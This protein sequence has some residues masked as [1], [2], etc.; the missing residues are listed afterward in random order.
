MGRLL[1]LDYGSKTTGVALTDPLQMIASPLETI[2]R[3]KEGK[4]RPTLRR[5]TEL[6]AA[7]EVERIVLG[8]PLNMDDS[9]G[10]RAQKTEEFKALLERRL[11]AEGL[12]IPVTLWDERLST[13][14]ADAVLEE[15]EVAASERKQYIDKIA[16]A[17]ILE[18]YMKN[19]R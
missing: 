16:A 1:G 5:I 19:H 4:L 18:D 9:R 10:E 14:D 8:Y 13:V 12:E 3:E 7:N 15:A 17:F 11:E 6:A 2:K